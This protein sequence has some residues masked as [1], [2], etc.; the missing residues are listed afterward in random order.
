MV[1]HRKKNPE[2]LSAYKK[3]NTATQYIKWIQNIQTS[4]SLDFEPNQV[5]SLSQQKPQYTPYKQW[6]QLKSTSC[7]QIIKQCT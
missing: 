6:A 1:I 2:N 3:F 4:F 7:S 5:D